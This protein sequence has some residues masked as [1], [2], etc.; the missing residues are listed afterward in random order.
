MFFVEEEGTMSSFQSV[1][2]VI[3]KNGLF[4]S[5]YS[6]LGS[7]YWYTPEASSKVNKQNLTRFGQTLKR[8]GIEIHS[9]VLLY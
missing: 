9:C 6:D 1:Q 3:E 5:F 4:V 2:E 7:H 8:L